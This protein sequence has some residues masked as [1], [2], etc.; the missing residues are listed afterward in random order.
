MCLVSYAYNN[1]SLF[2]YTDSNVS[3]LVGG[4][5]TAVLVII[6]IIIIIGIIVYCSVKHTKQ[7]HGTS[8]YSNAVIAECEEVFPIEQGDIALQENA[9]YGPTTKKPSDGV[10][11]EEVI[12]LEQRNISLVD[13]VAYVPTVVHLSIGMKTHYDDVIL[14]EQ[15]DKS[16]TIVPSV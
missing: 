12:S 4:L 11:Y 2:P 15:R 8:Y 6:I 10:Q 13:N 9:A 16:A 14:V 5:I 3:A 7:A 1:I